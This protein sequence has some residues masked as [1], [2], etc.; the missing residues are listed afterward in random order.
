MALGYSGNND[1]SES[2]ILL[3]GH[4]LPW[5]EYGEIGRPRHS[6]YAGTLFSIVAPPDNL[7]Q[8]PRGRRTSELGR[9][10]SPKLGRA[11]K[12]RSLLRAEAG[13]G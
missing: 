12:N 8:T 3:L 7:T 9:K 10:E 6:G 11:P 1:S 13:H 2:I 5:T 4:G